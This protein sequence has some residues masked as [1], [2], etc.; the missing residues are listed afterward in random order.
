[1]A[2]PPGLIERLCLAHF[3]GCRFLNSSE[4]DLRPRSSR[5]KRPPPFLPDKLV[6]KFMKLLKPVDLAVVPVLTCDYP[7]QLG[8]SKQASRSD[9]GASSSSSSL[10]SDGGSS[11]SN[12][13]TSSTPRGRKRSPAVQLSALESLYGAVPRVMHYKPEIKISKDG[14]TRPKFLRCA[15]SDGQIYHQL[16]KMDDVKPDAIMQQVF[17]FFNDILARNATQGASDDADD[18]GEDQAG[19]EGGGASGEAQRFGDAGT[20]DGQLLHIRTYN[21][22][23]LAPAA[24]LMEVVRSSRSVA[25][26]LH[27]SPQSAFAR[28]AGPKEW[29]YAKCFKE[30]R[31]VEQKRAPFKEKL[32]VCGGGGGGGRAINHPRS[33]FGIFPWT[34]VHC[35][36]FF[37]FFYLWFFFDN[38]RGSQTNR[39]FC[40]FV[41]TTI[42]GFVDFS[43]SL[44][45]TPAT[46]LGGARTTH[47]PSPSTPLPGTCLV[48]V[49]VTATTFYS[50]FGPGS[51]CTSTSA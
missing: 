44:F 36:E 23:P 40:K 29:N 28:Y 25:D 22:V 24:G 2:V 12:R 51:W 26:Y 33:S 32:K 30:I 3:I 11:R 43:K 14:L 45:R 48:S 15:A 50:T 21:V 4:T 5:H 35:T 31:D 8:S 46:G 34:R 16:A 10:Q 17:R 1:M 27:K 42:L 49:T 7:T 9:G 20:N 6:R 37:F 38:V 39:C 41:K 13:G 18:D 47:G 19:A